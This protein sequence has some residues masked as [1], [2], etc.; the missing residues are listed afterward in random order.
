[1]LESPRHF[2][3][4]P[5]MR[6]RFAT[7]APHALAAAAC[8]LACQAALAA[9]PDFLS[10]EA[11]AATCAATP[12]PVAGMTVQE[13]QAFVICNDI[14]IV[15]EVSTFIASASKRYQQAHLT[16][17]EVS[18]ALRAELGNLR[19]KLRL[20][21]QMLERIQLS[22]GQGLLLK[23]GSW[24]MDLNSD[25]MVSDW[26]RDLFAIPSRVDGDDG[27]GASRGFNREALIR[28]DQSDIYWM[29]S[30][31]YFIEAL[32]EI[33]LSYGL[34]GDKFSSANLVLVDPAGMR[35]A[36]QLIVKGLQVSE[37]MRR[38]VLAEKDDQQ[39]WLPN[40][41]QHDSVFPVVLD[42][43]DFAIWGE[44]MKHSQALFEGKTLLPLDQKVPN[45][46]TPMARLCGEGE[47][48]SI[49]AFFDAPPKRPL[50]DMEHGGLAAYCRK[51]DQRHPASGLLA[52]MRQYAERGQER[53]DVGMRF[54]RRLFWVN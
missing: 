12:R 31:H 24:V 21:R 41:R 1:M 38:S 10:Q 37:K 50:V 22:Q 42:G 3:R 13:Q 33:L 47:G 27:H 18:F 53:A 29:L 35:R 52:F 45:V 39:E 28:L 32:P 51:I 5:S 2:H 7:S 43:Q 6:K 20:G 19:D 36:R 14:A 30:Y 4:L 54:L 17:R 40:P 11:M 46:F 16:D 25:G 48:I 26:E 49:Q 8:S 34:D 9:P 15:K 44:A 23:P